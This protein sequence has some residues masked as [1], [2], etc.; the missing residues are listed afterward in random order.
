VKGLILRQREARPFFASDFARGVAR[1]EGWHRK[2]TGYATQ[3]QLAN[4]SDYCGSYRSLEKQRDR[5]FM[6]NYGALRCAG[7]GPVAILQPCP[8]RPRIVDRLLL[9]RG[10]GVAEDVLD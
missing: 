3:V 1:Y 8:K 4:A 6:T 9:C 10:T 2:S 7:V 5:L